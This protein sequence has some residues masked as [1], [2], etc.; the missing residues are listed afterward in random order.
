MAFN[1]LVRLCSHTSSLD[2]T[3]SIGDDKSEGRSANGSQNWAPPYDA[4]GL[5]PQQANDAGAYGLAPPLFEDRVTPPAE[6]AAAKAPQ[7]VLKSRYLRTGWCGWRKTKKSM[8]YRDFFT[9]GC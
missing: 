1:L 2:C 6:H 4:V 9:V 7:A 8:H 5:C 3:T